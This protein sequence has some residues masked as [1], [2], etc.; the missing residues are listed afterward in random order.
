MDETIRDLQ[1]QLNQAL[2]DGDSGALDTLVSDDCRIIGPKGFFIPK[3]EWIDVH[4]S[5]DYR[6]IQLDTLDEQIQAYG[7][8]A[9]IWGLQRS[10]CS[11][12]GEAIDGEF[13]VTHM[14][15]RQSQRWQLVATQFT[16]TTI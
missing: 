10:K 6:Q 16:A 4:K 3:S 12:R 13:R 14:W 2:L 9:V 15:A 5:G 8:A 7:D 1:R 11:Y